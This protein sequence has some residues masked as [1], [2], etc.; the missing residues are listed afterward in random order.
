MGGVQT[1]LP[2]TSVLEAVGQR[3][4]KKNQTTRRR[5]HDQKEEARVDPDSLLP[6]TPAE[7]L[8]RAPLLCMSQCPH[9][10]TMDLGPIRE[11]LLLAT[12]QGCPKGCSWPVQ[13]TEQGASDRTVA[14]AQGCANR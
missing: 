10:R 11:D 5:G 4:A 1:A 3:R 9:P 13:S 14:R 12:T 2:Q 7:G 6:P 8:G